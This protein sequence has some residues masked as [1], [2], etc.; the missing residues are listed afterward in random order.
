[1][2]RAIRV[3]CDNKKCEFNY[4]SSCC[5]QELYLQKIWN[6]D[7]KDWKLNCITSTNKKQNVKKS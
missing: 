7:E 1:M 2:T 4:K 3:Y 6:G 5:S